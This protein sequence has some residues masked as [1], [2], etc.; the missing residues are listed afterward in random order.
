MI[1]LVSSCTFP[2]ALQEMV[3]HLKKITEQDKLNPGQYIELTKRFGKYDLHPNTDYIPLP[4]KPDSLPAK[5]V[6]SFV[7]GVIAHE[8][9]KISPKEAQMFMTVIAKDAAKKQEGIYNRVL[10]EKQVLVRFSC[11]RYNAG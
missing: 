2:Q 9:L 8:A 11:I 3:L 7:F 10:L 5:D 6:N 1:F 4:G